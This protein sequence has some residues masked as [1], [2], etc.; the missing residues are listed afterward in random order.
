MQA[1][2]GAILETNK[3]QLIDAAQDLLVK[4]AALR[5]S[6]KVIFGSESSD[7]DKLEKAGYRVEKVVDG[8]ILRRKL[9]EQQADEE[10]EFHATM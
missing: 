9:Y 2:R 7:L 1:R 6:S 4:P 8:L 3:S 5:H 10:P